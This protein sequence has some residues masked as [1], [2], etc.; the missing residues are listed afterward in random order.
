MRAIDARFVVSRR[1]VPIR[2]KVEIHRP[3]ERL[4]TDRGVLDVR[5]AIGADGFSAGFAP[6][7]DEVPGPTLEHEA[8]RTELKSSNV[9]FKP[10]FPAPSLA[11]SHPGNCS[12]A[13]ARILRWISFEPPK[14]AGARESR[15]RFMASIGALPASRSS[16][17]R[18]SS[19]AT[20][21]ISSVIRW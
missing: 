3:R 21:S 11:P 12:T 8:K 4:A 1:L 5:H 15:N 19:P 6:L 10:S 16:E 13:L 2:H 18:A 17:K 20:T 9:A 7:R 14:I